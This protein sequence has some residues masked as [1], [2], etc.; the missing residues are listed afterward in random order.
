MP[1]NPERMSKGVLAKRFNGWISA[2]QPL[3]CDQWHGPLRYDRKS[4]GA[5][6]S[7]AN[8]FERGADVIGDADTC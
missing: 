5:E 6:S 3:S 4:K 2:A 1:I 8:H 7:F